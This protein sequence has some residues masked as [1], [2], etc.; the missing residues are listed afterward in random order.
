MIYLSIEIYNV[1]VLKNL[2]KMRNFRLGYN[3]ITHKFYTGQ[4]LHLN[5]NLMKRTYKLK[6]ET[7]WEDY[8]IVEI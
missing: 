4:G 6:V 7:I 5:L 1:F 8:G 2:L 3:I